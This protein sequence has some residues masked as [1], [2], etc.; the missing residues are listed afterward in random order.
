MEEPLIAMGSQQRNI[1]D[2]WHQKTIAVQ[3]TYYF[4]TGDKG[5]RH[6]CVYDRNA[7]LRDVMLKFTKVYL[8]KRIHIAPWTEEDF[9]LQ[10]FRLLNE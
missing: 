10:H 7:I 2:G 5:W 1:K 9:H 8:P 4:D 3:N 6:N